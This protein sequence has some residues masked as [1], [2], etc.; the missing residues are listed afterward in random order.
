MHVSA[1]G[2]VLVVTQLSS[3]GSGAGLFLSACGAL[4]CVVSTEGHRLLAL[5]ARRPPVHTPHALPPPG[6]HMQRSSRAY[7]LYPLT[8]AECVS[9]STRVIPVNQHLVDTPGEP[10]SG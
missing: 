10:A 4:C 6:V 8:S 9:L 7:W 5:R 3:V 1:Q 2:V